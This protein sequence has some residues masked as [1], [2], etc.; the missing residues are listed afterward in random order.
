M[1]GSLNMPKSENIN[2]FLERNIARQ[3][4]SAWKVHTGDK[5]SLSLGTKAG[6]TAGQVEEQKV[7]CQF[8]SKLPVQVEPC[9][10]LSRNVIISNETGYSSFATVLHKSELR[11]GPLATEMNK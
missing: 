8:P 7:L 5:K 11:C 4:S 1:S 10:S 9:Y 6:D 3:P 2:W